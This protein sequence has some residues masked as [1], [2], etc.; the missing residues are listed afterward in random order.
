MLVVCVDFFHK[1]QLF[2]Y[3][4][5]YLFVSDWLPVVCFAI[6]CKQWVIIAL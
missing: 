4:C 6:S 1:Y 3:L 2:I 5:D